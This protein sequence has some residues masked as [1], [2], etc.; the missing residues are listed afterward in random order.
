MTVNLD[1]KTM[2]IRRKEILNLNFSSRDEDFDLCGEHGE[3]VG[4]R[5]WVIN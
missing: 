4:E 1:I 5:R 3:G 2:I